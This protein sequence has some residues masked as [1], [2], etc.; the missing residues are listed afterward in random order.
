MELEHLLVIAF[1]ANIALIPAY[2][3]ICEKVVAIYNKIF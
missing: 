3:Y 2:A 1:I